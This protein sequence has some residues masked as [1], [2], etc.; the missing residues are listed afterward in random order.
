MVSKYEVVTWLHK[1]LLQ[2]Q[3]LDIDGQVS[4]H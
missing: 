3:L 1:L 2:L 4:F